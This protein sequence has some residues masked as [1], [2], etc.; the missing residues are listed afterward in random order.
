M[1][2]P[3]SQTLEITHY[4]FKQS[5][6]RRQGGRHLVFGLR[7]LGLPAVQCGLLVL[8][9]HLSSIH[10]IQSSGESGN[11]YVNNLSRMLESHETQ[12]HIS[13]CV[14]LTLNNMVELAV[15]VQ[16]ELEYADFFQDS[17]PSVSTDFASMDSTNHQSKTIISI[18]SWE[19]VNVE[20]Q[21]YALFYAI[22]YKGLDYPWI[23]Y[24]RGI[25]ESIPHGYQGTTVLKFWGERSKVICKF[26]TT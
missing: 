23:W 1:F 9:S 5:S 22:L 7:E 18:S 13:S 4:L 2:I 26:L 19:S 14:Q 11:S 12:R 6:L 16:V 20:N 17:H 25:L 21:L 15:Q 24:P 10:H 3:S 8:L